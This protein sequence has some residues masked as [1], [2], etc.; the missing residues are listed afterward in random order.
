[1][2]SK[3][4]LNNASLRR[5]LSPLLLGTSR[6]LSE[7]SVKSSLLDRG[8]NLSVLHSALTLF[9]LQKIQFASASALS[10]PPYALQQSLGAPGLSRGC[11]KAGAGGAHSKALHMP[12][13]CPL[14]PSLLLCFSF[15]PIFGVD[16]RTVFVTYLESYRRAGT[17]HGQSSCGDATM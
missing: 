8:G 3:N 11:W 15:I 2:K 4:G 17:H 10:F 9:L 14:N 5:T 13:L 12:V 6:M 7:L 16:L 1:M